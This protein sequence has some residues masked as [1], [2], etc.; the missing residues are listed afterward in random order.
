MGRIETEF[1]DLEREQNR[2][3]SILMGE[4]EIV[5]GLKPLFVPPIELSLKADRK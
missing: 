4:I 1:D 5:S 2:P 3:C